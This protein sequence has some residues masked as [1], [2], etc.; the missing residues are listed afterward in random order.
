M[1]LETALQRVTQAY[2]DLGYS[3]NTLGQWTLPTRDAESLWSVLEQQR[4]Q[5]VLEVGTYVG[6]S[7]MLLA[8]CTDDG[9]RIH[10]IDPD[11]PL[12][13]EMT[14]MRC[15]VLEGKLAGTTHEIAR[16]AARLLH[17]ESKISFHAGGF[18][19]CDT[20]STENADHAPARAAIG[21]EI[22]AQAGP[23]DCI[24]IDGLHYE[25][26]VL[27]DLELAATGL[28]ED[29]IILLHDL[30][31]RWGSNVHS[32]VSRFLETRPEWRFTH[33]RYTSLYHAMGLLQRESSFGFARNSPETDSEL[34]AGGLL[35]GILPVPICA[36]L[37]RIFAPR[38]VLWLG[39]E[40]ERMNTLLGEMG[41]ERVLEAKDAAAADGLGRVDLCLCLDALETSAPAE[42]ESIL[43]ACAAASDRILIALTPPGEMPSLPNARPLA[44]W[45]RRFLERGYLLRDIIRPH[46]E[47][48]TFADLNDPGC[49][50]QSSCNVNLF[51]AEHMAGGGKAEERAAQLEA[52]ILEQSRRIESLTLQALFLG[53]HLR[54]REDRCRE[55]DAYA[56]ALRKDL[57]IARAQQRQTDG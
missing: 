44:Y 6:F 54:N 37:M 42:E 27:S 22:L 5:N 32:A 41:V 34:R 7:T 8:L 53:N 56:G 46:L 12:R 14:T 38:D 13:T 20:F 3:P 57:A 47:P 30:L 19:L 18:S 29:G 49:R 51:L 2:V 48:W 45:T 21:R 25:H 43:N 9:T 40:E 50:W 28:T 4:P 52:Q 11:L 26:A 33:H 10:T 31:G 35:G 36:N 23:F 55:Y 24:F 17:V 16:A 1:D 15:P 39:R